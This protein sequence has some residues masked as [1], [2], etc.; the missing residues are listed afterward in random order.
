MPHTNELLEEGAFL[1]EQAGIDA[2]R[3]DAREL[4]LYAMGLSSPAQLYSRSSATEQEAEAYRVLLRRRAQRYPLQYLLGF[5]EFYG[6]RFVVNEG[7]LIP[8]PDTETL[9][10]TALWLLKGKPSPHILDLCSGTGV[11]AITLALERPDAQVK[12]LELSEQ[13]L[14]VLAE[15][16]SALKAPVEAILGDVTTF[17]PKGQYD[18][19]LSNPPY[20]P[21]EEY[22]TLSPEV[23]CE[24][25][26]AFIAADGGMFFYQS[27]IRRYRKFLSP[28]GFLLLEAGAG[29]SGAILELMRQHQYTDLGAKKDLGGIE[30]AI[31]GKRP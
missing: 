15:N 31:F 19:I 6:R 13:A 21:T 24:P 11:L 5:W 10:D 25:K 12:A 3:F 23:H 2:P 9:V 28:S 8:R 16:I 20:I 4:L 22:L 1:L 26:M 18:L 7:V 27:I 30:R 29:Q 14:E 17:V